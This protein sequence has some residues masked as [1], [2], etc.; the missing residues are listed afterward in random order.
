MPVSFLTYLLFMKKLLFVLSICILALVVFPEQAQAQ[1]QRGSDYQ[2]SAGLRLSPFY[3]ASVKHFIQG[4]HALEGI[5]HS[6]WDAL[7][8]TGL[9]EIHQPLL[10][11]PG[12]RYY[13]GGGAHL[14]FTGPRYVGRRLDGYDRGTYGLVGI[15]GIIGA[16]YTIQDPDIPLN[17][18]LDW[19]PTFDFAP[20]PWFHGSELAITVRYIFNR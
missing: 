17:I 5:L 20:T 12:L 3:G 19:K 9:Y 7:K 16:E 2:T 4:S 18:S 10:D 11:E 1:G 15:D 6:S 13:Y 14:G 8:I